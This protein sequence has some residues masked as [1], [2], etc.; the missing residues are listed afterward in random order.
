MLTKLA[1]TRLYEFA[2]PRRYTSYGAGFALH[3]GRDT[4]IPSTVAPASGSLACLVAI[5]TSIDD[6][7]EDLQRERAKRFK[8]ERLLVRHEVE[9]VTAGALPKEN[10]QQC[11]SRRVC[12]GRSRIIIASSVVWDGH[13]SPNTSPNALASTQCHWRDTLSTRSPLQPG[14]LTPIIDI[15]PAPMP[16]VSANYGCC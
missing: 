16:V 6:F 12:I 15:E 10:V 8:L 3:P 5:Q 9:G 4:R 7:M 13:R 14:P 1:Q 2:G 11:K